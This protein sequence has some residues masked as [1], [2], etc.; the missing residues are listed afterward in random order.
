MSACRE[1]YTLNLFILGGSSPAFTEFF[2]EVIADAFSN[3][4][5]IKCAEEIVVEAEI[6]I[7]RRWDCDGAAAAEGGIERI[8]EKD[9]MV[10]IECMRVGAGVFC[11]G[12]RRSCR[13][14]TLPFLPLGFGVVLII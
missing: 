4:Q 3:I 12:S 2:Y 11:S 10:L 5:V 7:L 6:I 1:G 13:L 14:L 9:V 8:G